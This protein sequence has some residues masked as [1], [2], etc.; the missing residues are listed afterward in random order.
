MLPN[1]TFSRTLRFSL[2]FFFMYQGGYTVSGL[3]LRCVPFHLMRSPRGQETRRLARRARSCVTVCGCRRCGRSFPIASCLAVVAR[4]S[5]AP[6]AWPA[7]CFALPRTALLRPGRRR[8][9]AR[10]LRI[11]GRARSVTPLSP[12]ALPAKRGSVLS[13]SGDLGSTST[14]LCARNG[15][16]PAPTAA[17]SV[18]CR[19]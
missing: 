19:W 8:Y 12:P 5:A 16:L 17:A 10:R 14:R 4:P 2:A 3:S 1:G 11:T 9:S 6:A 13:S 15:K 7:N 18:G